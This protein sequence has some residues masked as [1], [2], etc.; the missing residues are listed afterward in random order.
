MPSKESLFLGTVSSLESNQKPVE[1][2]KQGQ[3]V[4]IKIEN[5]TGEAPRMYDRHFNYEDLL[6]SRISRES[7]DVCKKY[8]RDDLTKADWQLVIELKKQ[9]DIM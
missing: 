9:L 8:F 5:T 6:V 1:V 7:I 3:E 4:C 2:A